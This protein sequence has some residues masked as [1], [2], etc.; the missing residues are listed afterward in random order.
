MIPCLS[1][2]HLIIMCRYLWIYPSVDSHIWLICKVL[3]HCFFNIA[4]FFLFL[5]SGIP[6]I[7]MLVHLMMSQRYLKLCSFL[8]IISS[9]TLDNINW[10]IFNFMGS[11]S[12]DCSNLLLDLFSEILL[13]AIVLFSFRISTWYLFEISI[14]WYSLLVHTSFSLFPLSSLP[15]VLFKS[16]SIFKT[17]DLKSVVKCN[18]WAFLFLFFPL[19]NGLY[20]VL[21]EWNLLK[22]IEKW[23]FVYYNVVTLE[24]RF[25]LFSG[26]APAAWVGCSYFFSDFSNFFF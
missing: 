11:F 24:I 5:P 25:F 22:T 26:F 1:F 19:Q 23:H 12:T 9:L 3:S 7:H 8:F 4:L 18:V 13:L 16:L 20:V 14:C 6:I 21:W 2:W 15:M 10:T 17:I